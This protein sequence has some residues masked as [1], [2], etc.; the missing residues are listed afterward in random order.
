MRKIT[1]PVGFV[2][3][4][5]FI[6]QLF[7]I[8]YLLDDYSQSINYFKS[9]Q[10]E[11]FFILTWV[12]ILILLAYSIILMY[13]KRLIIEVNVQEEKFS[14]AFHAAP[15]IIMLS[16]LTDGDI[17][18][19]N[20]YIEPISGY[21]PKELI[22]LNTNDLKIW[23]QP[24]DRVNFISDLKKN[25]SVIEDEYEFRK[26][27]GEIFTGL[28]SAEIIHINNEQCIISVID[29]ITRRKQTEFDLKQSEAS[30]RKLNS[31]KDKFFSIIAHDLRSPF[32]GILGFSEILIEQVRK[33]D[34][35]GVDK[36]ANIINTSSHHAVNLLSN[37]MEWSRS[38][39]GRME[40]SPEYIELARMIKSVVG[41]IMITAE[42]KLIK[43]TLNIPSNFVLYADK[44]M[45]E[46]VLRN[47][48]SNA[49]KFTPKNGAVIIRAEEKENEYVVAVKDSGVGIEKKNLAKLFRI[50]SS[51]STLGSEN[52]KGT[53][54]GLILCKDFIEKHKGKI[55]VESEFGT[56][57]TFYFSLPKM[58]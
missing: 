28:I 5:V 32:N 42:H 51:Y 58:E 41:L 18:E 43:I 21:H 48:I 31:T 29:D 24:G 15:F 16:R 25:G 55:W 6:I 3:V 12:V 36:Y 38:Q 46:T 2:F 9:G 8:F 26:K 57:S 44:S 37:L 40:F 11:A 45:I 20:N 1:R 56:G 33:K 52:E 35:T 22:G 13:N 17:F 4:A 39:T 7:R 50:D 23:K 53:G 10:S 19:V 34:Y 14:K 47:L 49:I 54:L 27:S 30:L